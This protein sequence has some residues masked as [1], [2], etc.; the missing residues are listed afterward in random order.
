MERKVPAM[1]DPII[2]RAKQRMFADEEVGPVTS[3]LEL[4]QKVY[5][6]PAQPIER[7]LRAARDAKDHEH[8]KLG[9]SVN[10]ND[11]GSFAAR[12]DAAIARVNGHAPKLIEGSPKVLEHDPSELRIPMKQLGTPIR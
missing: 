12:L 4:F 2:Q 6:D 9:V 3:S 5:R 10:I 7:R 8:P 11:D 1:E